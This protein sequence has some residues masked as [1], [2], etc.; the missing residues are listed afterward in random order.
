MLR[1]DGICRYVCRFNDSFISGSY[2]T[3]S[4]P[5]L[6]LPIKDDSFDKNTTMKWRDDIM[7]PLHR[8]NVDIVTFK[9]TETTAL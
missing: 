4:R 1:V 6:M 7:L 2:E 3:A 9:E 8:T 5:L